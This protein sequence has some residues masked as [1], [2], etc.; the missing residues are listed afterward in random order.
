[1]KWGII[2]VG[3]GMRDVFGAGV[4]DACLENNI[5]FDLGI[6]VSAG[7]ANLAG[8]MAKQ[9]GRS[10]RFYTEYAFRKEY[11]SFKNLFKKG[12]YVDLDYIYS[13]LSN[14]NGEDPIDY[15]TFSSNPMQ[16]EVVS[17]EAETGNAVYFSKKDMP[18]NC[19]DILKASSCLPVLCRPYPI[20]GEVYFDGGMSDPIPLQ[21]ALDKGCDKIVLILTRP[22]TWM[23][24]P[25][26]DLV[27]AKLLEHSYPE[28]SKKLMNRAYLYNEQLATALELERSGKVCIV[29]PEHIENMKTLNKDKEQLESL[30]DQG[31]KLIEDIKK[32][33]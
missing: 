9:K 15:S 4:F 25:K 3:G 31:Y 12:N 28:S 5:T 6:G 29:S 14:A 16:L 30:Y 22:K 11:M 18:I 20:D 32:F 24:D 33:I 27:P 26:K 10:K 21:R 23:R 7:S 17:T 8:F 19:Y 1:M 2:D 13:G